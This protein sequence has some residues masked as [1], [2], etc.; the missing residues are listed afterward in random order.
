MKSDNH[1]SVKSTWSK[2]MISDLSLNYGIESVTNLERALVKEIVRENRKNKID[3]IYK[4][5]KHI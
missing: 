4:S 2:E 1:I 3:K 5:Q